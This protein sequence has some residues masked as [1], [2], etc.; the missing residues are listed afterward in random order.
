M[1][2]LRRRV[3]SIQRDDPRLGMDG[4]V[5]PSHRVHRYWHPAAGNAFARHSRAGDHAQGARGGTLRPGAVARKHIHATGFRGRI[6]QRSRAFGSRPQSGTRMK[7]SKLLV[8]YLAYSWCFAARDFGLPRGASDEHTLQ[9]S[10]RSEQRR[11]RP[12]ELLPEG[13]RR[14]WLG[15]SLLLSH[16][17]L[18]ICSFVA[19]RLKPFW[20]QRNTSYMRDTT[21]APNPREA[22]ISKPQVRIA[23]L[24]NRCQS[25]QSYARQCRL[26][27]A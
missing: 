8:W 9:R 4:R 10:V 15:A 14:K 18:R 25:A 16:R 2:K 3:A 7:S 23:A 24:E 26:E 1:A 13:L 20:A 19:P 12:K 5:E 11:G 17:S 6:V 21:L 27:I 22:P